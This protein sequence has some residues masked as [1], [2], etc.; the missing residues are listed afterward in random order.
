[1]PAPT[2]LLTVCHHVHLF[3]RGQDRYRQRPGVQDG[4]A[5]PLQ[6]IGANR[7]RVPTHLFKL[8][9]DES[10]GKAWAHWQSNSEE[11]RAGRPMSYGEL[12]QR[13]GMEL[14]PGHELQ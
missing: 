8:V 5:S 10:T 2:H 7:V 3:L 4:M 14:L 6:T 12:T 11:A 1:V 9:Y 13:V